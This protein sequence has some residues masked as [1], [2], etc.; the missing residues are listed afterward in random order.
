MA[1]NPTFKNKVVFVGDAS[2]GK[3]TLLNKYQFITSPVTPTVS[4]TSI[5]VSVPVNEETI[6]LNV[7]DTAGQEAYKCLVPVYARGAAV[8]AIVFDLTKP[9]TY[10][11]IK[12]WIKYIKDDVGVE[13]I[14][15]V[16][17]KSDLPPE[18]CSEEVQYTFNDYVFDIVYTSAVTGSNVN[19][20][21]HK[22][23]SMILEKKV[24]PTIIP[25]IIITP[26]EKSEKG[27][28]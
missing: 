4:A 12:D 7:W 26:T 22:I 10:D 27:C 5:S 15:I 17:N 28:C 21:F 14:V 18:V 13:N 6:V 20:L 19:L 3:T 16:A 2:V 24:E 8:A 25:D 23:A 9:L 11:H 1:N